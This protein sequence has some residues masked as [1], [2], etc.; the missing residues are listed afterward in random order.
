M[1][2][3]CLIRTALIVIVLTSPSAGTLAADDDVDGPRPTFRDPWARGRVLKV[4]RFGERFD[5]QI[6]IGQ[7]DGIEVGLAANVYI[8][9][10]LPDPRV[11]GFPSAYV[12]TGQVVEVRKEEATCNIGPGRFR[13]TNGVPEEGH[14]VFVRRK[15]ARADFVVAKNVVLHEGRVIEWNDVPGI[16]AELNKRQLIAP[17]LRFTRAGRDKAEHSEDQFDAWCR[18]TTGRNSYSI[19]SLNA[20]VAEYY[21]AITSRDDPLKDTANRKVGKVVADG[22]PVADA[23]VVVITLD[24]RWRKEIYLE[25]G[26]L[27]DPY[28]EPTKTRT[29]PNGNFVVFPDAERFQL[30][31]LHETGFALVNSDTWPE[32]PTIELKAWARISGK[33]EAPRKFDEGVHFETKLQTPGWAD[34]RLEEWQTPLHADRSFQN[35]RIPA[36]D[37]SVTRTVNSPRGGSTSIQHESF[38]LAPGE[39]RQISI[40]PLTGE[41]LKKAEEYLRREQR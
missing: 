23:E 35:H 16:L 13:K 30:L 10:D 5:V 38:V 22:K 20:S 2:S 4:E 15:H 6:S 28:S 40:G 19:G 14:D 31:V 9:P 26:R 37:I 11:G 33:F 17:S 12:A 24:H 3:D 29:K 32:D 27:R 8:G 1:S 39:S 36:G 7:T 21:D 25:H 41:G 34:I 18:E